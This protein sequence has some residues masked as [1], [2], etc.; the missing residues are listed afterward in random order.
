MKAEIAHGAHSLHSPHLTS[1]YTFSS[2]KALALIGFAS[3]SFV[4]IGV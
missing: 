1:A 2:S 3:I 4:V